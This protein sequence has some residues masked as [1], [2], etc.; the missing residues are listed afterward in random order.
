MAEAVQAHEVTSKLLTFVGLESEE[1]LREAIKKGLD[2]QMRCTPLHPP[3]A[4]GFYRWSEATAALR[5]GLIPMKWKPNDDG[6]LSS[7][8][9]DDGRVAIVIATGDA[10]TGMEGA[11]YPTTKFPRGP[12]TQAAVATNQQI[13]LDLIT[14]ASI[15]PDESPKRETWWLL[16]AVRDGE[17]R[18]E[19]S[20]PRSISDQGWIEEWAHRIILTPHQ[21]GEGT[22]D[23]GLEEHAMDAIDVSVER[24]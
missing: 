12:R 2:A 15:L 14:G 8:V 16:A 6:N 13:A 5:L 11:P 10:R 9:R 17:V 24:R 21:I 7:I 1:P 18:M 19:L 20:L 3:V 4:P 23:L 22:I